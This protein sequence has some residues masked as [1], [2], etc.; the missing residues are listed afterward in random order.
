MKFTL[1]YPLA[2]NAFINQR[3]GENA[4]GFYK[5]IGLAGHNG[6]D[7]SARDG[8]IV[9]AAHDGVV[10]FAGEDGSGGLGIVLRTKEQF[11]YK[12]G[13]NYFKTIYW[14]LEKGSFMVHASDEVKKGQPIAKADNTGMSTGTHLHFGLK[15]VYQGEKDWEWGNV[16]QLNGYA[17]AIDAEPYVTEYVTPWQFAYDMRIGDENEE[18]RQLQIRL[19]DKGFFPKQQRCTG[20]YGN[21]TA[22][23]VKDF[24]ASNLFKCSGRIAGPTIRGFLNL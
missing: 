18:V 20:F 21:I 17:G 4:N 15:P 14:H 6:L 7:L 11:D 9:Y 1:R 3:F 22:K 10:T 19:Q 5:Q 13:L 16:E 12:G 23:A 8:D 2:G 24:G